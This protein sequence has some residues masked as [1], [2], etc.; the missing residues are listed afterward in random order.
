MD[1]RQ[2]GGVGAGG[3]GGAGGAGALLAL[4][5]VAVIVA[6]ADAAASRLASRVSHSFSA[7]GDDGRLQADAGQLSAHD[8]APSVPEGIPALC[9]LHNRLGFVYVCRG[10]VHERINGKEGDAVCLALFHGDAPHHMCECVRAKVGDELVES[11]KARGEETK[12]ERSGE[13][14]HLP[15]NGM[16]EEECEKIAAAALE[17]GGGEEDQHHAAG[18]ESS[19]PHHDHGQGEEEEDDSLAFDEPEPDMRTPTPTTDEREAAKAA[20]RECV[21]S[22][23]AVGQCGLAGEASAGC[24]LGKTL[25]GAEAAE[26]LREHGFSDGPTVRGELDWCGEG[27]AMV[28]KRVLPSAPLTPPAGSHLARLRDT[29]SWPDR[30]SLTFELPLSGAVAGTPLAA[31]KGRATFRVA[32]PPGG[33]ADGK[34]ARLVEAH[35]TVRVG[36][37]AEGQKRVTAGGTLV[38]KAGNSPRLRLKLVGVLEADGTALLRTRSAQRWECAAGMPLTVRATA[39]VRV[40]GASRARRF[41]VCGAKDGGGGEGEGGGEENPA[42]EGVGADACGGEPAVVVVVE[43]SKCHA[44]WARL[45]AAAAEELVGERWP[46]SL[47]DSAGTSAVVLATSCAETPLS[48]AG[49]AADSPFHGMKLPPVL[50][51]GAGRRVRAGLNVYATVTP[52]EAVAAAL[53]RVGGAPGVAQLDAHVSPDGGSGDARMY[54]AM[55]GS[56]AGGGAVARVEIEGG[57]GQTFLVVE[58]ASTGAVTARAEVE[59][60]TVTLAPGA[61]RQVEQLAEA[62]GEIGWKSP[63]KGSGL[64]LSGRLDVEVPLHNA[65]GEEPLSA[66]NAAGFVRVG[67]IG[68][69]EASVPAGAGAGDASV[70]FGGE[71]SFLQVALDGGGTASVSAGGTLTVSVWDQSVAFEAVGSL[72][73]DVGSSP[74]TAGES[75]AAAS[76]DGQRRRRSASSRVGGVTVVAT[77]ARRIDRALGVDGLRASVKARWHRAHDDGAQSLAVCGALALPPAGGGEVGGAGAAVTAEALDE[78]GGQVTSTDTSCNWQPNDRGLAKVAGVVH[79]LNKPD[80]CWAGA[81]STTREGVTGVL[82]LVDPQRLFDPSV[83]KPLFVFQAGTV[84]VSKCSDALA[85]DAGW[86]GLVPQVPHMVTRVQQGVNLYAE[87][88]LG[89]YLSFVDEARA[90]LASAAGAPQEATKIFAEASVTVPPANLAARFRLQFPVTYEMCKDRKEDNG[91]GDKKKIVLTLRGFQVGGSVDLSGKKAE[92]CLEAGTAATLRIPRHAGGGEPDTLQLY[93]EGYLCTSVEAGGATVEV[94]TGSKGDWNEP[95]GIKY[96][97]VQRLGVGVMVSP[98]AAAAQLGVPIDTLK[99]IGATLVGNVQ[100]RIKASASLV[101]PSNRAFEGEVHDLPLIELFRWAVRLAKLAGSPVDDSAVRHVARLDPRFADILRDPGP[102]PDIGWEKPWSERMG[103]DDEADPEAV[104]APCFGLVDEAAREACKTDRYPRKEGDGA[105]PPEE[106]GQEQRRQRHEHD[107]SKDGEGLEEMELVEVGARVAP[108]RKKLSDVTIKRLSVRYSPNG[109]I[110]MGGGDTIEQG[111]GVEG[112]VEIWG[113][114]AAINGAMNS[115][116][117]KDGLRCGFTFDNRDGKAGAVLAEEVL[118]RMKKV[119]GPFGEMVSAVEEA[120]GDLSMPVKVLYVKLDDVELP[121]VKSP[122]TVHLHLVIF[123]QDIKHE[124][125]VETFGADF[126]SLLSGLNFESVMGDWASVVKAGVKAAAAAVLDVGRAGVDAAASVAST[127]VDAASSV[128]STGAGAARSGARTTTRAASSVASTSTRTV[129]SAARS[130]GG[131]FGL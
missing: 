45:S 35:A 123:G 50:G 4:L 13:H 30:V 3:G 81:V 18:G 75:S 61:T 71:R 127:G 66:D 115:A 37:P 6:G 64:T 89:R 111:V 43:P 33:A 126:A 107:E 70:S 38:V 91:C 31:D 98:K 20:F 118:R 122:P 128:A 129:A 1:W 94:L 39:A 117:P 58:A 9:D 93:G 97:V 86:E 77:G 125:T 23:E 84:C 57:G 59:R 112:E 29:F 28:L 11:L 14:A 46:R 8:P 36:Q 63:L 79:R 114:L 74:S 47:V 25:L 42:P 49:G 44:A 110:N 2:P 87:A 53:R 104:P 22:A 95:F 60:A 19:A 108:V 65:R 106:R 90:L 62:F 48:E 16:V 78:A 52:A 100:M 5:A 32:A 41:L 131:M 67:D 76:A 85:S 56:P 68:T 40:D 10:V 27:G 7:H 105:G 130:V 113:V 15:L 119:T 12:A 83:F 72:T 54:V 102:E 92:G 34:F 103:V 88:T 51:G 80:K 21:P 73:A 17:A 82:A 120:K 101:T 24:L 109:D 124:F 99:F 96:L 55:S 116:T 69:V 26:M 121:K